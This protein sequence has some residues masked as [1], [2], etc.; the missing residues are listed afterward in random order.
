MLHGSRVPTL[1]HD[2]PCDTA[3][4]ES[5]VRSSCGEACARSGRGIRARRCSAGI[6]NFVGCADWTFC[7]NASR[8]SF[9]QVPTVKFA[10]GNDCF[11]ANAA[12]RIQSRVRLL[13][14]ANRTVVYQL[15]A[16]S[17]LTDQIVEGFLQPKANNSSSFAPAYARRLGRFALGNAKARRATIARE[18]LVRARR[19]RFPPARGFLSP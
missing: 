1:F 15:G 10:S 19:N 12:G 18:S 7:V 4:R 17:A 11:S 9:G 14:A 2:T 5:C 8:L 6:R 16:T 3:Q 13:Y